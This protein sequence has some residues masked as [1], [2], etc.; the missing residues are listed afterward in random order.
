MATESLVA[1]AVL[2]LSQNLLGAGF[3]PFLT[4]AITYLD[5]NADS[6]QSAVGVCEW[7]GLTSIYSALLYYIALYCITFNKI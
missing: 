3:S 4:V 5:D 6:A 2:F 7:R 1:F